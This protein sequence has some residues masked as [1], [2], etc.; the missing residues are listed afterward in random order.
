[1]SIR[2]PLVTRL[3][4]HVEL[5]PTCPEVEIGLGVPRDPVRLVALGGDQDRPRMVQPSTGRDLTDAMTSFS[6]ELLASVEPVDGFLLKSRS[7]SCG[8]KDTKIFTPPK[9]EETRGM[10][11]GKGAG[12]FARAVLERFGDRAIEDEGRLT[13]FRIRHHFL[14]KMFTLAR[15]RRTAEAGTMAALVELH[16]GHK[17]LLMA[18]HQTAMRALGR[19]VANPDRRPVPRVL[20]DYRVELA[21]A[22]ARPARSTSHVNV[23]M[24]AMGYFKDGL[25]SQEKRHFLDALTEYR[26]GRLPLSAPLL[27]LRSWIARFGEEYLERQV[28]FEP[29]PRELLDLSDSGGMPPR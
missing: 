4:P 28:Y 16:A 21:R 18:Y 15:L 17:L 5:V 24:H 14:T 19:L 8:I 11:L 12:L 26:E 20:A 13:N 1:V 25:T 29:Y 7:P 6:D 9:G 27:T 10:P 22:L 23:L 2:T 3:Q